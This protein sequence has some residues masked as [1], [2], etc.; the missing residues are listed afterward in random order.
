MP[1]TTRIIS[2]TVSIPRALSLRWDTTARWGQTILLISP[3]EWWIPKPPIRRLSR[4]APATN[5][6]ALHFST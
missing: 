4:V 3:G 6:T 1:I 5:P 2:P